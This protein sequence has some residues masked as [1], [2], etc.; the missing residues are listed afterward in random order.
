MRRT[1]REISEKDT[2]S[3]LTVADYGVLSTISNDGIPYG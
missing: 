1:D 3:I 2:L